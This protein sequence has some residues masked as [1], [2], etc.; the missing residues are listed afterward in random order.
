MPSRPSRRAFL[1]GVGAGGVAAMV[2]DRTRGASVPSLRWSRTYP[3]AEDDNGILVRDV[4]ETPH[5][6]V[7][8]GV[9]SVGP[10]SVGWLAGVDD[11]GHLRW[12]RRLGQP[13]SWFYAGR[14][15]S[16]NRVFIAGVRNE[17]RRLSEDGYPDP[18]LVALDD[19]AERSTIRW[20]R[21]YQPDA[22]GGAASAIAGTDEGLVLAGSVSRGGEKTGSHPWVAAVDS[23]GTLQWKWRP[24]DS[25]RDGVLGAVATLPD[26]FVAGGSTGGGS[27]VERAWLGR[28]GN[29]GTLRWSETF[30]DDPESRIEALARRPS[31]GVVAVGDRGFGADDD[32]VGFLAAVD[33]DG[34]RQ[35][36][37]EYSTGN[38]NWMREVCPAGDGY[39][40]LGTRE[41]TDGDRR[42]AW[43]IRV[44]ADGR[45]RWDHLYPS[46]EFVRGFALHPL[47]GDGVLV[48][49]DLSSGGVRGHGW[50]AQVG[51]TAPSGSGGSD[52]LDFLPTLPSVPSWSIPLA[53]G[54]GLG[55]GMER[56]RRDR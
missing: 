27:G 31:G 37:R 46:D 20:N 36:M 32:G 47:A 8:V 54:I 17:H 1:T 26:G 10:S 4:V 7:L 45:T 16:E 25:D 15:W 50:L 19:D 48:G 18:W 49:G 52:G 38:W 53:A 2:P 41:V 22:P 30:D 21:T 3:S 35:W 39:Y 28:F 55:I 12:E 14:S 11:A 51:G 33:G 9:N 34:T 24:D 40:L 43:V 5:G 44:D 6:F 29:D 42:G 23:N 13:T 56:L